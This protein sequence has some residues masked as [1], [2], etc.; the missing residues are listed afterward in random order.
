LLTA[1]TEFPLPT[2]DGFSRG[3]LTVGPDGNLWFTENFEAIVFFPG[4]VRP[5]GKIDRITPTGALTEFPLLD[6]GFAG[7]LTVGPDGDLWFPEYSNSSS[8]TGKIGRITPSGALTEFPLPDHGFA[9]AMTV[10][11]DGDLWFPQSSPAG[12]GAIGR[13]TSAGSITEFPLPRAG[14]PF[15]NPGDLTVGP[16]GDLWF[17][18]TAPYI[19]GTGPASI[20]RA[21]LSQLSGTGVVAVAHSRKGITALRLGLDEALD[22][23]TAGKR[24]FYSLD[25]A[26]MTGFS[27]AVKIGSVHY[28]RSR[29]T[30]RLSL[31]RPRQGPL[32]VTVRSGILAAAVKSDS[33]AFTAVLD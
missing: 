31:A 13:I 25:A 12:P 16:D 11:P 14:V 4:F 23:A 18:E 1:I 19:A 26:G 9:G 24:R 17:Y 29:N 5:G 15:S 27:K 3:S 30:V 8:A 2:E 22:P 20:V 21:D 28:D 7:A 10:G 33:I 6:H 32:L